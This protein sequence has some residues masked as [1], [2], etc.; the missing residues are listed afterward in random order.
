MVKA[1]HKNRTIWTQLI[2]GFSIIVGGFVIAPH[3]LYAS[4]VDPFQAPPG[5][6]Y[7]ITPI[8]SSGT[9]QTKPASLGVGGNFTVGGNGGTS[10]SCINNVCYT[11]LLDALASSANV[12]YLSLNPTA[13]A[14]AETGP[15]TI[16][17]NVTLY[18]WNCV[19]APCT[20]IEPISGTNLNVVDFTIHRSQPPLQMYLNHVEN[21][22]C[23][24]NPNQACKI[25]A[26]CGGAN[27]CGFRTVCQNNP[28]TV[29]TSAAQCGGQPCVT[30]GMLG[31]TYTI[32]FTMTDNSTRT[33]TWPGSTNTAAPAGGQ[34]DKLIV[35]TTGAKIDSALPNNQTLDGITLDNSGPNTTI[36]IASIRATWTPPGGSPSVPLRSVIVGTIP[37]ANGNPAVVP[38]STFRHNSF[39]FVSPTASLWAEASSATSPYESYGIW[40]HHRET[41]GAALLASHTFLNTAGEFHGNVGVGGSSGDLTLL[42][43]DKVSTSTTFSAASIRLIDG[44]LRLTSLAGLNDICLYGTGVGECINEWSDIRTLHPPT[45]SSRWTKLLGDEFKTYLIKTTTNQKV[46]IGGRE[47]D[48]NSEFV[49]NQAASKLVVGLPNAS[50]PYSF[51]CGDGACNG[52]ELCGAVDSTPLCATDCGA[53]TDTT[54]PANVTAASVKGYD[55]AIQ[56]LWTEPTDADYA[57]ALLLRK[58]GSAPTSAP[59][60]GNIYTVGQA[61]GDATVVGLVVCGGPGGPCGMDD[62]NL[63]NGTDY[64]YEIYA[65]DSSRNYASDNTAGSSGHAKPSARNGRVPDIN[66]TT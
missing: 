43:K 49:F 60:N 42:S 28:A 37:R 58:V 53:C 47:R 44:D 5:S 21:Y 27:T 26:D 7:S 9:N 22:V 51:T 6:N 41:G 13:P 46:N 50:S 12:E 33:V 15:V 64:Y 45:S 63:T 20:G 55:T 56:V 10:Q 11:N 38:T 4:W 2:I 19:G 57:G 25:N 14:T 54:P 39:G 62:F 30:H 65:Y 40:A 36:T 34:A 52:S 66:F 8:T 61:I 24:N 18:H 16:L 48:K 1:S 3:V 29:C 31:N 17:G 59:A 23:S 32:V 35:S